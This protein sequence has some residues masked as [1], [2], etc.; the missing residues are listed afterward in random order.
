MWYRLK[1]CHLIFALFLANPSSLFTL[2]VLGCVVLMTPQLD[3]TSTLL[4]QTETISGGSYCTMVNGF[5]FG[6]DIG[7]TRLKRLSISS[8]WISLPLMTKFDASF[9][10][11]QSHKRIQN[12]LQLHILKITKLFTYFQSPLPS[13]YYVSYMYYELEYLGCSSRISIL[14]IATLYC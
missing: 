9:Q 11:T 1:D 4:Y 7:E 5:E 8:L 3:F 6:F 12:H 2:I 14:S 13:F 10:P